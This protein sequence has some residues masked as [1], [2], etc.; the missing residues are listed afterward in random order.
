MPDVTMVAFVFTE[1]VVPVTVVVV[2]VVELTVIDDG[3]TVS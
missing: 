3:T 1:P 2:A